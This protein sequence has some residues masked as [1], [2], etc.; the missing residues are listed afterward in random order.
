MKRIPTLLFLF[1]FL[2]PAVALPQ[3]GT[4]TYDRAVQYEFEVPEALGEY[5][6]MIPS[7]SISSMILLFSASES[8]MIP[9]PPA[10]EEEELTGME[11]RAQGLTA[12]LKMGSLSRSDHEDLLETYVNV[13]E[14]AVVETRDFMGRTFLLTGD[15][16]SYAWK[17]AGEE[18]EFLGYVV[19]KATAIQDSMAIEAWFTSEIPVSAGPGTF[20]GLPGLILV[21][22]VD[23]GKT[24]YSATDV[25]LA[26]LEDGS[27]QPPDDGQEVSRDEYEEIVAEKMA[28]L[29]AERSRRRR[30]Q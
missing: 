7:E 18:S 30:R 26:H 27:I 6:D 29:E 25:K 5:K 24:A 20:G 10:E 4:V 9:A 13:E 17:L 12:R 11:S 16:P 21:V 23:D 19:Q 3:E 8:V 15:Q 22:S 2:F 14:G 1:L 28:E